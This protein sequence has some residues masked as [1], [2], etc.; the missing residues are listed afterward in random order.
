MPGVEVDEM[1]RQ[2]RMTIQ[3]DPMACPPRNFLL[4]DL[5]KCEI[6]IARAQGVSHGTTNTTR[7]HD[8][9]IFQWTT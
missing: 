1:S 2:Q 3:P 6:E 8:E 5:D 9:N 7:A 4:I